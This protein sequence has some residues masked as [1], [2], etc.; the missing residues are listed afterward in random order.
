MR[1]IDTDGSE[2]LAIHEVFYDVKKKK[3]DLGWSKDPEIVLAEDIAGL[4]QTLEW[5][6]GAL[7]K[8]ILEY[9]KDEPNLSRESE[10]K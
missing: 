1:H 3:D 9:G 8:P 10:T 5:M 6:L 4:R 2:Y 7:D